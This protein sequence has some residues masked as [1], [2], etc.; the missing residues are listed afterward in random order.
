[1]EKDVACQ[2]PEGHFQWDDYSCYDNKGEDVM[3][4]NDPVT[5]TSLSQCSALTA[6]WKSSRDLIKSICSVITT[7]FPSSCIQLWRQPYHRTPN[8]RLADRLISPSVEL[9]LSATRDLRSRCWQWRQLQSAGTR[10]EE[11][12]RTFIEADI[13][14]QGVQLRDFILHLPRIFKYYHYH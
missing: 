13:K 12:V 2:H 1:M 10:R 4:H 6:S 3:S 11:A 8:S 14:S 5:A 7:S 9:R